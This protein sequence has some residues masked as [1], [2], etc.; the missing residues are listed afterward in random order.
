MIILETATKR[1]QFDNKLM[2]L[3]KVLDHENLYE[4]KDEEGKQKTF[5]P[6]KWIILEVFDN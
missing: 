5:I 4:Y 2:K 3:G 1:R 6:T